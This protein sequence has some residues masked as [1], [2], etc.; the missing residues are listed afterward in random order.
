MDIKPVNV[1]KIET[2]KLEEKNRQAKKQDAKDKFESMSIFEN[3]QARK[4]GSN[5]GVKRSENEELPDKNE[6]Q[7]YLPGDETVNLNIKS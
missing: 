3:A 2:A 7:K 1:D 6:S 4:N 5:L